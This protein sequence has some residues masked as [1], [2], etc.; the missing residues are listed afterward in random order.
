MNGSRKAR[1]RN[2][3]NIISFI[4]ILKNVMLMRLGS[5]WNA[6]RKQPT[7]ETAMSACGFW[8]DVSLKTSANANIVK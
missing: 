1:Q 3:V 4:N 7:L 5:F 8:K 6:F 2:P